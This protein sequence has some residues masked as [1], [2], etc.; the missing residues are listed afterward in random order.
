MKELTSCC[1]LNCLECGAYKATMTNDDNLRKQTAD[2]WK[3]LYNADIKPEHINC[4][5]C[6][7]DDTVFG[8]CKEC[9]LRVCCKSK[10]HA[11]CAHCPDYPCQISNEYA[12]MIPQGKEKLDSI[13][14][15]L[16]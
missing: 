11:N 6:T 4:M 14:S 3:K 5:G 12:Q 13:R 7:S 16:K 2:E 15:G 1:G 10:G 9:K 8:F